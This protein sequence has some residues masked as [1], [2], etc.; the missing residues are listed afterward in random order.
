MLWSVTQLT[1][2]VELSRVGRYDHSKNSTQLN[3]T[4]S[5]QFSVSLEVLNMFRTSRRVERGGGSADVITALVSSSTCDGRTNT[6]L[7]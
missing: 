2:C 1:S 5:R 6:L 7:I 4:K 3:W